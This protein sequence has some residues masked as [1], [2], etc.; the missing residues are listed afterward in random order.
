MKK[1]ETYSIKEFINYFHFYFWFHFLFLFLFL[2]Y[3]YFLFI[4]LGGIC[5]FWGG[6]T[7]LRPEYRFG[8]FSG[9]FLNFV[10]EPT[11]WMRYT[12][13]FATWFYHWETHVLLNGSCSADSEFAIYIT[14]CYSTEREEGFFFELGIEPTTPILQH[15]SVT[16]IP[17]GTYWYRPT[18]C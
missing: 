18:F 1:N 16:S 5:F 2:F 7:D 13:W 8:T 14:G 15:H 6:G 9:Y 10:Y 3:F 12:W 17:Y 11:L 4:F